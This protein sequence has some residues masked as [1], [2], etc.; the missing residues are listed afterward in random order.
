MVVTVFDNHCTMYQSMH[1]K[2]FSDWSPKCARARPLQLIGG[3]RC[4]PASLPA[5]PA[6]TALPALPTL[7][8]KGSFVSLNGRAGMD[9]CVLHFRSIF[10]TSQSRDAWALVKLRID[11]Y[12]K[13]ANDARCHVIQCPI[14]TLMVKKLHYF[15]LRFLKWFMCLVYVY[16]TYAD[17][18][19]STAMLY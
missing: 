3:G 9:R 15:L 7:P 16:V 6:P 13:Y 17:L 10:S 19:I 5:L 8:E 18:L 12:Q 2:K 1:E 14:S 4:S 11:L